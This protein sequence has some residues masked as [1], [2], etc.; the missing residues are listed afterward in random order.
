MEGGSG[1]PELAATVSRQGTWSFVFETGPE[2]IAE[3]ARAALDY[4]WLV[5]GR[6][7]AGTPV[8]QV[9]SWMI[10]ASWLKSSKVKLPLFR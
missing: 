8:D 10:L 7:I 1:N 6:P 5:P 3:A 9:L 2:G 4:M